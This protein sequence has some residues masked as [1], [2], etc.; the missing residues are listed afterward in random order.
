VGLCKLNAVDPQLETAWFQPLNLSNEKPVSTFAAFKCNL[1]LY[2]EG[3]VRASLPSQAFKGSQ[4]SRRA[5]AGGAKKFALEDGTR[6]PLGAT[7]LFLHAVDVF[8]S[9]AACRLA[10]FESRT[11]AAA[12]AAT[13]GSIAATTATLSSP[14]GFAAPAP[15]AA[16]PSQSPAVPESP[17]PGASQ[18]Q[19]SQNVGGGGGVNGAWA[20]GLLRDSLLYRFVNDH[21]PT[22]SERSSFLN[23]LLDLAGA[24]VG[25][26]LSTALFCSQNT[27]G[28]V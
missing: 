23:E 19:Q 4:G 22:D 20:A 2:A 15:A 21:I 6:P 9:D 17:Q 25:L 5:G 7:L 12:A 14:G 10:V 26:A 3:S 13:R 24:A 11:A 18:Q 28:H 8:V 16:P 27:V 1:Y